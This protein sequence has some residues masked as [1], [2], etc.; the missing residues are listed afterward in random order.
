MLLSKIMLILKFMLIFNIKMKRKTKILTALKFNPLPPSI[1]KNTSSTIKVK[2]TTEMI[3]ITLKLSEAPKKVLSPP[4]T[5]PESL[6][7]TK[8]L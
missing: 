2:D 6:T 8:T 1:N 7:Q 5:C 4:K 3:L